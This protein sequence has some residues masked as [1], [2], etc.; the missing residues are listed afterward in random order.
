M[1]DLEHSVGF[2]KIQLLHPE[3][4]ISFLKKD[5]LNFIGVDLIPG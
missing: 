5:K 3:C 2:Y 4:S 1:V